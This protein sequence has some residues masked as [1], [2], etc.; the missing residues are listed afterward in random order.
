MAE[1]L[2]RKRPHVIGPV[3]VVPGQ[4]LNHESE[5][6]NRRMPHGMAVIGLLAFSAASA[7]LADVPTDA[8][9]RSIPREA[10]ESV[11]VFR[12]G[13]EGI[14]SFRI[15]SILTAND[16]SLLFFAEGRKNS[17]VDKSPTDIV[18]KRSTDGGRTWSP[19]VRLLEGGTDAY[20]DPVPLV[21]AESGRLFLFAVHWPANDH[22]SFA[23]TAWMITS[24]DHGVTWSAPRNVTAEIVMPGRFILGLGPGRGLT[25][26]P[27]SPYAGRLI[28]PVR[29]STNDG[30]SQVIHAT[31]SDN[32]GASWSPG[33]PIAGGSGELTMT[34]AAPG[35]LVLN[36]RAS[37]ARYRAFSEDGGGAWTTQEVDPALET[38]TNGCHGCVFGAEGL[39][40][41]AGPAG[42]PFTDD[43][44]NRALLTISRSHD[45]G[46]TWPVRHRLNQRAAGYSDLTRRPGGGLALAFETADTYGFTRLSS[47]SAGWIR[48]DLLLLPPDVL[49]EAAWFERDH[50]PHQERD[51]EVFPHDYHGSGVWNGLEF[52]NGWSATGALSASLDAQGRLRLINSGGGPAYLECSAAGWEG[53]SGV[54]W[55]V[56]VTL[57][58]NANPNGF[59][60]WSGNGPGRGLANV[61]IYS[62]RT[63]SS[64]SSFVASQT[65]NTGSFHRF[66]IVHDAANRRYHVFRDAS[67]L[68]PVDGVDYDNTLVDARFIIGDTTSG[69]FGD[70]FDVT[71]ES[72]RF[73]PGMALLPIGIDSDG[74]RLPDWWEYRHFGMLTGVDPSATPAND[75]ITNLAKHVFGVD[76]LTP[77]LWPEK[78]IRMVNAGF[79]IEW[80]QM[81]YGS[82]QYQWLFSNTL[83]PAH[84]SPLNVIASATADQSDVPEG[85]QRVQ[86]EYQAG[87]TSGFLRLDATIPE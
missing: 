67:R 13:D 55:T 3:R 36:R 61:R 33:Q 56:E 70:L 72:I 39:V 20:M 63:Q 34:E 6:V 43:F 42:I 15:P 79:A 66:R 59:A 53:G 14:H 26:G 16:G 73:E 50:P 48:L 60:I 12:A 71:I 1:E 22:S 58:F 62:D 31:I 2:R 9:A 74:N 32:G 51:S 10:V 7:S 40:F 23:N 37:A 18:M 19:M 52:V 11:T 85:Y 38:V 30:G 17:W 57:R 29:S 87:S 28:L 84:W 46:L 49:D 68:T 24:D 54:D 47:R 35:R 80:I 86:A 77:G 75:G 64:S 81:R 27:G 5:Y 4:K 44:D 76:P 83:N 21:D 45:G 8:P 69:S 65:N 78:R 25:M 82:A 41:Y